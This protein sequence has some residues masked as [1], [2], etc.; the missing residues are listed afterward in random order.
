MNFRNR[1][2]PG[3]ILR[4]LFLSFLR[5][6]IEWWKEGE[7]EARGVCKLLTLTGPR[8][9]TLHGKGGGRCVER[10]FRRDTRS[11]RRFSR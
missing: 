9:R 3:E 8:D 4:E 7:G 5:S 6:R 10:Y 2:F 11:F 1:K